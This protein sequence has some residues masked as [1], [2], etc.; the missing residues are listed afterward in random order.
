LI[1]TFSAINA[2]VLGSGRVNYDIA[3]DHELP[4]YFCHKYWGKPIGFLI[5]AILSIALVNL[6]NLQSIS[7]AGSAGFLLIFAIVN[8]IG[9][10]R[11]R[12][13]HSTN[14]IHIIAAILCILAF[15]TLLIQQFEN[16]KL[17]VIVSVGIILFSFLLEY[18]YKE[19]VH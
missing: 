12:E 2:T 18:I 10:K 5:T 8:Y 17:G 4:K 11:Y 16:N 15:F 1:S 9:H 3:E 6:F 14:W 7:T 13:L 19:T